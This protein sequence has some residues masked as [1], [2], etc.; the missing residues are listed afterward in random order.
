MNKIIETIPVEVMNALEA[1]NWPGNIRE[2]ENFIERS[3]ILSEGPVLDLPLS[4]LQTQPA[5]VPA[6]LEAMGR[7]YIL[8][9]LRECDGMIDGSHG[10]AARLG[11]HP[12][13]LR[14]MMQRIGIPG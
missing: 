5:P 8:R 4:E 1:R 14:S 9:A 6:T 13:T 11:M 10:A 3:I 12:A 7:K 2:L